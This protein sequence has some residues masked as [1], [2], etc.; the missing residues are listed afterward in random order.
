MPE[1]P[2][3]QQQLATDSMLPDIPFKGKTYKVGR[4]DGDAKGRLEKLV[5]KVAIDEV[6][7]MKESLDPEAYRE[8]FESRTRSLKRYDTWRDGWQAI[9]FDPANA[10]LF[11]WSLLQAHQPAI[12]E[13]EVTALTAEAPEEVQLALVQVMSDFFQMLLAE[14]NLTPDQQA[15]V[16][17]AFDA[18]RAR[19]TPTPDA[20]T[21]SAT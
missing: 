6:R 7:A 14:L 13:K 1:T 19:L 10:H 11:L 4:P 15:R 16:A 18:L 9:V 17:K 8:L 3:I 20:S 12:T 5:K 21:S 2:G